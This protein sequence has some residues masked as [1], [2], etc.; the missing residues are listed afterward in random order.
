MWARAAP[1]P[2]AA[3]REAIVKLPRSYR[4]AC[5]LAEQGHHDEARQ[6]LVSLQ[7]NTPDARLKTLIASDLAVLL[8]LAGD[9]FSA[10]QSLRES[11]AAHPDCEPARLN[12]ALLEELEPKRSEEV[13]ALEVGE[14]AH[15]V[16]PPKPTGPVRVAVLSFLFNWPSTGGGIVHTVELA[17]FLAQASYEV[18]HIYARHEPWGIGGVTGTLPYP[19]QPLEFDEAS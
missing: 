5:R 9:V 11:L 14:A 7:A 16:L 13:R 15:P 12:L 2:W 10:R 8:A 19:S 4:R 6:R 18:R 3:D 1:N 17:R